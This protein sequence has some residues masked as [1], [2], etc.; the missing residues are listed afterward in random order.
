MPVVTSASMAPFIRRPLVFRVPQRATNIFENCPGVFIGCLG[1]E[2]LPQQRKK[3]HQPTK[4][5]NDQTALEAQPKHAGEEM[6]VETS[7]RIGD[8]GV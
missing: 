1:E 8:L 3:G 7:G 5:L 4:A 2:H 6:H